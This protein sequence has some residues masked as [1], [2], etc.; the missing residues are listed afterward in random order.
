RYALSVGLAL[1]ATLAGAG[2]ALA[3]NHPGH[4]AT[5][6]VPGLAPHPQAWRT[7]R[8][9]APHKRV[10]RRAAPHRQPREQHHLR[11]TTSSIRGRTPRSHAARA[12]TTRRCRA[13]TPPACAGLARRTSSAVC[14]A[15]TGFRRTSNLLP[16]TTPSPPG[17]GAS[18]RRSSSSTAS[19][20]PCTGTR[21]TT[22]ARSTVVLV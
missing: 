17:I 5:S 15:T 10:H 21:S 4:G 13:R 16:R 6:L 2:A 3:L 14:S 12:T 9:D 11:G 18:T 19:G 8:R 7:V 22:T 1:A 20:K